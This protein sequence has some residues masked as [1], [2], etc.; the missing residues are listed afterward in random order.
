[1]YL[2]C[3]SYPTLTVFALHKLYCDLLNDL[4][5]YNI[6]I[7]A[8]IENLKPRTQNSQWQRE[9]LED[10]D[11]LFSQHLYKPSFMQSYYSL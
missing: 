9:R 4:V 3:E 7:V 5:P 2:N 6:G 10:V 11:Y 8:L 1:M